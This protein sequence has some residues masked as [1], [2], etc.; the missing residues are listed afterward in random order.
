VGKYLVELYVPSSS[1]EALTSAVARAR[2]A[3]SEMAL[4]GMHVTY[5]RSL[6]L[7]G[8]ELCFLLYEGSSAEV[9]GEAARRAAITFERIVEADTAD[10]VDPDSS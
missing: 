4:D 5:L 7:P 9:V 2:T 6:F 1:P 3:A 10:G 8:D